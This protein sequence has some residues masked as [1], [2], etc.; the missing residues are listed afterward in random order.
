MITSR[1]KNTS[2]IKPTHKERHAALKTGVQL[3][4]LTNLSPAVSPAATP[5]WS[6]GSSSPPLAWASLRKWSCDWALMCSQPVSSL[7]LFLLRSTSEET[8]ALLRP[9]SGAALQT[10][11]WLSAADYSSCPRAAGDLLSLCFCLVLTPKLLARDSPIIHGPVLITSSGKA[12]AQSPQISTTPLFT[13]TWYLYT[14][15]YSINSF[16]VT[17]VSTIATMLCLY[18]F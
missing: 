5:G 10:G 11:H 1:E 2:S 17:W 14:C 9:E 8:V 18:T 13:L 7:S 15:L 4:W 3:A 16:F 12:P 6:S